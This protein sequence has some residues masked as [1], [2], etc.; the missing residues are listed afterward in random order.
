MDLENI[1]FYKNQDKSCT[2]TD[3]YLS[4]NI[5]FG[6]NDSYNYYDIDVDKILLLKQSHN[7]CFVRYNDMNK[8]KHVPLQ[9]KI[10]NFSLGELHM[11]RSGIT[12]VP[13][14][15]DDEEF[16]ITFDEIWNKITELI[17]INS[18]HDFLETYDDDDDDD[19]DE[20]VILS[21]IS[22]KNRNDPVF[23]FTCVTKNSFQASLVQYRY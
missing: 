5:S 17:G 20:F 22:D 19:E 21:T 8:K 3:L 14:E 10:E 9:L 23:L 15:S 6:Y 2:I 18:L 16:F 4:H 1:M 11:F 12:L 13:I 7:E